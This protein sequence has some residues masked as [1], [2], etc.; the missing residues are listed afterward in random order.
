MI[1]PNF[2]TAVG[3]RPWWM[4]SPLYRWILYTISVS[5][6]RAIE[7]EPERLARIE[8]YERLM[9]EKP[10]DMDILDYMLYLYDKQTKV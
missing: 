9:K 7:Y 8:E 5:Y 1:I 6:S 3:K 2:E 4:P 10:A